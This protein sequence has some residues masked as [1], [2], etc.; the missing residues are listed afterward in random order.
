MF[1]R[2]TYQKVF[3]PLAPRV[4]E[5]SSSSLPCCCISGISSRAIKGMVPKAMTIT[6]PG[7]AKMMRR[8]W[9]A[10]QGPNQ[11]W[12]PNRMTKISPTT[13]GEMAKGM[14]ISEISS[15]LQR[16]SNLGSAQAAGTPKTRLIGRTNRTTSSDRRIAARA[17][18]WLTAAHHTCK[19]CS[20][21]P[22]STTASGST[23][24]S[25]RTPSATLI[26]IRR[27]QA[28]SSV[29]RR[30]RAAKAGLPTTGVRISV[31]IVL[32]SQAAALGPPL[33][34]ID[35]QQQQEGGNQHHGADGGGALVVILLRLGNDQQGRN[36][37]A[38]RHVAGDEYHGAVFAHRPGKGQRVAGQQRWQQ[39]RQ[40]DPAHGGEA[41]GAQAGGGFL[42][43]GLQ[44]LQH[45]LYG[46]HHKGQTY[47]GQGDDDADLRVG[48][49]DIK[50]RQILA[51]PASGGVQRD[52][53]NTRHRRGQGEGQIH[54][55][56]DDLPARKTVSHQH[57]GNERA[58]YQ[59]D[60]CAC[61]RGA[62]G[63][64]VGGHHLR[65]A[66]GFPEVVPAH[67][68][69]IEQQAAYRNQ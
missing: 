46:A 49:L 45:W 29:A 23:R 28:G 44:V 30:Q 26:R 39:R 52:Q 12:E 62:K 31:V 42:A 27:T 69:G 54:Q 8:S 59:V 55:R 17:S 66:D 15:G 48:H 19:R 7:T 5:A 4:S 43:L 18:G 60:G 32:S 40:D 68:R 14:S 22:Y 2:V 10:S 56:I 1:G 63:Q 35:Q 6:M 51:D 9:A 41:A 20:K 25:A 13:T 33:Q 65:M 58:K 36:L 38:V 24:H 3:Q 64:S 57:P 11:P 61:Q 16:N 21:G 50:Q 37:G 67:Q 53:C 34:T 47:V